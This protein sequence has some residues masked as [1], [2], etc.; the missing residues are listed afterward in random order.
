VR[1]GQTLVRSV[2]FAEPAGHLLWIHDCGR[3]LVSPDGTELLCA[4]RA[5]S[6]DWASMIASQALPLAATIRGLE[7]LHAAGVVLNGEAVLLAGPSG[8]GKSSLA[9]ALLRQGASLLSDDA[10]ALSLSGDALI[11]HPGFATLHLRS[12]EEDRLAPHQ[13]SALGAPTGLVEGKR[14][15]VSAHVAEAAP[16]AHVFLLE[17]SE[18]D[19]I[20]EPLQAVNPFELIGATFNVSV[21]TPERLARQLDV[22]SAIASRGFAHR[23]RVRTGLTASSLAKR[24]YEYVC[25]QSATR[26]M[27]SNGQSRGAPFAE[28]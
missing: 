19:P 6:E 2:D 24:L 23:L 22:V 15:Y 21:R 14:R 28:L 11:A 27:C 3:V 9:A 16:L 17:R 4:P 13:R 10:V 1:F 7:V 26:R 18:R 20:I 25:G 8:V 5:R 12:A